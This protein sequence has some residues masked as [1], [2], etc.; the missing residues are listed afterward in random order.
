MAGVVALLIIDQTLR[1]P[2]WA[3]DRVETRLE[4]NMGGLQ[5]DFGALEFV[6]GSGWRPRAA[7]R[8]VQLSD[9]EG[10]PILSLTDVE[11]SL[12]MRPLLRGEVQPK[13]VSLSGA[14]AELRRDS[15]GVFSLAFEGNGQVFGGAP[16]LA[17]LVQELDAVFASPQLSALVDVS[18][19]QLSLR[20]ED[21]VSRQAW[22]VDGGALRITREND[23]LRMAGSVSVLSGRD[24]ASSLEVNYSSVIGDQAAEFGVTLTDMPARDIASQAEALSWLEPVRALLSGALRGGVDS[25][26]AL[27]PLN[28]TLQIGQ[29]VLQPTDAARPIPFAAAR[30]Y[31]TFDPAEQS[32][33][34]DEIYVDSDWVS[35]TAEGTTYLDGLDTGELTGLTG[36]LRLTTTR[37]NPAGAYQ[38]PITLNGAAADFQLR[39]DPFTLTLGEVFIADQGSQILL[40]GHLSA[41]ETGWR[42]SFD[43]EVDALTP[44]RLVDLWPEDAIGN[45][46]GWIARNLTGGQ[47]T[48]VN[49]AFRSQPGSRPN[50]YI[51]F[52]YSDTQIQFMRTM[53][54]I[55]GASGH[56]SLLG[57]RFVTTATQG[58]ILADEGGVVDVSGTSF[59][60]PDT[61]I[62]RGAPAVA[63]VQGRGTITSV[64]SLLNREPLNVLDAPGLPVDLADGQTEFAGTLALPL[65]NGVTFD[66]VEFFADGIARNVASAV[67]VPGQNVE[68][69]LL[70][71]A[72]T[73]DGIEI[74]G[75][76]LLSNIPFFA[77]WTQLF[78]EPGRGSALTGTVRLNRA[79]LDAFNIG[80]PPGA[81]TG[82]GVA[83]I[84]LSLP[85]GGP[86]ELELTSDLRGLRLSLPELGWS[87][88]PQQSGSLELEAILAAPAVVPRITLEAPG[89]SAEGRIEAEEGGGLRLASFSR[90]RRSDWMDVQAQLVGQGRNRPLNIRILNGSLDLRR[91]TFGASNAA[92]GSGSG[93]SL[94]TARLNRLQVTDTVALREFSGD[95]A[96]VRGLE[97]NFEGRINGETPVTGSIVPDAGRSAVRVLSQDAGGVFR[98]AGIMRQAYGG[99]FEMVL[100]PIEEPGSFDGTISVA[101]TSV[102]DAPAIAALLNAISV[103]GLLTELSGQGIVF[104]EVAAQFQLSPSRITLYES[105]ATGPSLGLSMDGVF[106]VPNQRLN[107]QGVISPI[108]LLNQI[109]GVFTPRRGEGLF[110]FT[111]TLTGAAQAPQVVVNPLSGLAP[112]VFREIFRGQPPPVASSSGEAPEAEKE[113]DWDRPTGADR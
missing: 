30:T 79:T 32:L 33:R 83:D 102:R 57:N 17:P 23:L 59:I 5:L 98:D 35:G 70:T 104:S 103:V 64:L 22:T 34:F 108:Y 71:I 25:Q 69:P 2:Q 15:D 61:S 38:E 39:L 14:F 84:R 49:V 42:V 21:A 31:F 26:G 18:L 51:D 4:A 16:G 29:G 50:V 78:G 100:R 112:G 68:A 85:Q 36:Q 66:E 13:F 94:M 46:R 106:D 43:G 74:F 60:V 63:R 58:R 6:I 52:D 56:A 24:F 90:V 40:S 72:A 75:D 89:L 86:P 1:A 109:G 81:V 27:M 87:K 91:A 45:T 19:D 10:R 3:R 97:G 82:D 67:L 54:P 11:A 47:L 107:M 80:L 76:G 113:R 44:E 53:P 101:N 110:G 111:Y 37:V 73:D 105:R 28:A 7:L 20:Y 12:A 96:L 8:D 77:N 95:F 48:D 65:R 88:S 41:N 9:A 55:T 92:S 62:R 99:S 93:G